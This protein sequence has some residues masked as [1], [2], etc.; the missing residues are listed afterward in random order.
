MQNRQKNTI[1]NMRW[2]ALSDEER[3]AIWTLKK[4]GIRAN[5][6]MELSR[7]ATNDMDRQYKAD[8]TALTKV[9]ESRYD[10]LAQQLQEYWPKGM[11]D[12][13][14]RWR[15]ERK[16]ISLRLKRLLERDTFKDTSDED[17]LRCARIYISNFDGDNKYMCLLPY[18]ILKMKDVAGKKIYSSKLGDMLLTKNESESHFEIPVHPHQDIEYGERLG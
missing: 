3:W 8:I 10:I 5:D 14:W 4:R 7:Y 13:K 12:G 2:K 17:V 1:I 9:E 6:Y 16:D 18:F 15:G 11:K